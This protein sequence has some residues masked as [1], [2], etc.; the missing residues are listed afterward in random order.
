MVCTQQCKH[1]WKQKRTCDPWQQTA[2]ATP[3]SHKRSSFVRCHLIV[4]QTHPAAA[5]TCSGRIHSADQCVQTCR[6]AHIQT[7]HCLEVWGR[8]HRWVLCSWVTGDHGMLCF[9]TVR[10]IASD[11]VTPRGGTAN[12]QGEG[13]LQECVGAAA[14]AAQATKHEPSTSAGA[15]AWKHAGCLQL[16]SNQPEQHADG[17]GLGHGV[18]PCCLGLNCKAAATAAVCLSAT[19]VLLPSAAEAGT[20]GGCHRATVAPAASTLIPCMHS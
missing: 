20:A 7:C 9:E 4:Y 19:R 15:A 10:V 8:L 5:R 18:I 14:S 1:P 16:L 12:G 2:G 6:P 17:G 11:G 13:G 3:T